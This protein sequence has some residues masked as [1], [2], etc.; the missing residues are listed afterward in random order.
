[1]KF[2]IVIPTVEAAHSAFDACLPT[3]IEHHG[4]GHEVIVVDDGSDASTR[5]QTDRHCERCGFRFFGTEFNRG[6]AKTVNL[7]IR[8]ARGDVVVLVN[9]DVRFVRPVLDAMRAA[10]AAAPDV[11]IV[12][13]LLLFPGGTV[14]H[15]GIARAGRHFV[16]RG[17]ARRPTGEVLQSSY[18]LACTGALLGL[19]RKMIEDI[20]ELDERLRLSC[21]DVEY[22]LRAW[23]RGWKVL[24]SSEVQAIHEEGGTRG[25]ALSEKLR[26]SLRW[27]MREFGTMWTFRS[28]LARLDVPAIEARIGTR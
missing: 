14:Q 25:A 15:G 13:G 18:V 26:R 28:M 22:C 3:F 27:T 9:S 11:G 4:E 7:G 1:V 23:S 5:S 10:F 12:G 20:G 17:Y 21:E 6:F 19:R 2:S 16:H 24:Y 8:A